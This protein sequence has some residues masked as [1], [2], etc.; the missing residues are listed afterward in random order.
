[1]RNFVIELEFQN[2][3]YYWVIDN[4]DIDRDERIKISRVQY[5]FTK[6]LGPEKKKLWGV[7]QSSSA[8]PQSKLEKCR[9]MYLWNE[10][11]KEAF[12]N[13]NVK[14]VVIFDEI[15]FPADGGT[16][17]G[18]TAT[19][20]RGGHSGVSIVRLSDGAIVFLVIDK[21]G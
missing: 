21:A 14:D 11:V 15:F 10:S 9:A 19:T 7:R 12:Q 16:L 3:P 6:H 4:D 5:Y 8:S 17:G 20:P 1:M 18:K 2:P 13:P